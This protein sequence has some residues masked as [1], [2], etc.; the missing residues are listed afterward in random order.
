MGRSIGMMKLIYRWKKEGVYNMKIHSEQLYPLIEKMCEQAKVPGAAVIVTQHGERI[1]EQMIGYR[2]VE[3]Q[4]PVTEHTLFG[5]AS[6]TKSFATL[7]I[8]QLA[9]QG[10][11]SVHDPVMDWIDG[12]NVG[13]RE[14]TEAVTIHHLMTHTAGLPGMEGV[15][16]AR[17]HSVEKDLDGKQL[18]SL[19]PDDYKERI[20]TVEELVNW[21]R[22]KE[23]N[24]LAPPGL[25]CNYSNESFALL[26]VIIEQASGED[27]LTYMQKHILD[28]LEMEASTFLEEDFNN[29]EEVTELYAYE[30]GPEK[31]VT[32]SP[33][34]W[35]VGNI[36]TNGSL[37]STANEITAYAQMYVNEGTYKGKQIISKASLTQMTHPHVRA[38][39]ENMYG[40][41]LQVEKEGTVF[42]HGGAVKGVS[43][44]FLVDHEQG[45]TIVVLMNIADA[46]AGD[47]AQAIHS[48]F[49]RK[50]EVHFI[51][52]GNIEEFARSFRS[53]EGQ[54]LTMFVENERLWMEGKWNPIELKSIK[55]DLFITN[56][57]RKIAFL[58]DDHDISGVFSGM[59]YL[60]VVEE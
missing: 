18:F 48:Q 43:A 36:Y 26:Q 33:A 5:V 32:H 13:D 19:D 10:K 57:G 49:N 50:E 55:K 28:P 52:C 51:S 27:V 22:E 56:A 7:A 37:K 24:V 15:H 60:P 59:R 12:F 16:L 8:M 38:P 40:Y 31:V 47:L 3:K 42:G 1:H 53:N 30:D 4:L 41:G 45:L 6:I 46:P 14:H 39:N 20:E 2:D 9:E 23:Y 25:M 34:W 17:L 29:R 54:Q 44:Y 11:L 58:R 35:D 21:L